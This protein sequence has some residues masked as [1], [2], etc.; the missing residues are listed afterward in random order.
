MPHANAESHLM[1]I[2]YLIL[3]RYAMRIRWTWKRV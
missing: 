2:L 1:Q 3:K